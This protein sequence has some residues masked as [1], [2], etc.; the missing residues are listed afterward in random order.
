[1]NQTVRGQA[2]VVTGAAGGIAAPAIAA[3]RQRE[4]RVLGIDLDAGD[5]IIAADVAD[6]AAVERAVDEAARR[7]GG[8]DILITCAG[9]GR[10]QDSG[11]PPNA[12]SL[13]TLEVNFLGT[14]NTTAAALPYLLRRRGH[15]VTVASGLAA[16]RMPWVASYSASK[17]AVVAFS[18]SLRI[19]YH[20]RLTVTTVYPGYIRTP[21]HEHAAAQGAA[22]QGVV[23]EEPVER[24]VDAL[25]RACEQRPRS[26]ATSAQVRVGMTLSTL[27]PAITDRVALAM[28]RRQRRLRPDPVF[29]R[30]A[31][32]STVE[33]STA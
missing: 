29:V 23:P 9:I 15:V 12:E 5:G 33:R 6:P 30:G 31:G 24:A 27:F 19:E 25:L 20:G 13:R 10:A 16:V 28:L 17:R 1:M 8:I 18:D 22:L 4:A 32:E 21:I 7:L 11:D 14:W 2:I 3:L 26:V